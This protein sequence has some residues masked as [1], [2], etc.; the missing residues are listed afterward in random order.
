MSK[1]KTAYVC[2]QCG[3]ISPRWAG[4]CPECGDWNALVEEPVIDAGPHLRETFATGA[5]P[6]ALT[7]RS[8]EMPPRLST[9]AAD[10]TGSVD[11]DTS[12]QT[13]RRRQDCAG[14]SQRTAGI[15]AFLAGIVPGLPSVPF[16]HPVPPPPARQLIALLVGTRR[17]PASRQ[18][19]PA[20]GAGVR[21]GAARWHAGDARPR[22]RG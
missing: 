14:R 22:G 16:V 10:P 3:A 19:L 17:S 6:V 13:L 21:R 2:Q 1:P 15:E 4:R 20:G 18:P 5:E 7:D 12:A 11:S 9:G 8:I